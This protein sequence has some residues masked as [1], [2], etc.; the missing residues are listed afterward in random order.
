MNDFSTVDAQDEIS[1]LAQVT[2]EELEMPFELT[3]EGRKL[4]E[5]NWAMLDEIH[6]ELAPVMANLRVRDELLE[7][8]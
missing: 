1:R 4:N 6:N 5:A 2:T 3:E 8:L 7:N